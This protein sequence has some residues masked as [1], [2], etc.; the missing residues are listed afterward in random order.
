MFPYSS[1]YYVAYQRVSN[2]IPIS[3]FLIGNV[4]RIKDISNF[5]NIL[6]SQFYI[7]IWAGMSS[8]SFASGKPLRVRDTAMSFTSCLSTFLYHIIHIILMSTKP[9]VS[10]INTGGIISG[11]TIVT[12]NHTFWN[13]PIVNL[14]RKTV[15][16]GF[17]STK[18]ESTIAALRFITCPNPTPARRILVYSFPKTQFLKLL[19]CHISSQIKAP[20]AAI[21]PCCHALSKRQRCF[22]I[23]I[24]K[25]SFSGN[26][27]VRDRDIIAHL[28]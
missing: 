22:K 21:C 23:M 7:C 4:T 27:S 17:F 18:T 11:R 15:R 5:N 3:Q 19:I 25:Y 1:F 8:V 20:L 12:N 2:I 28:S 16:S 24:P 14:V 13:W 26:Y 10:R 6:G 9:K